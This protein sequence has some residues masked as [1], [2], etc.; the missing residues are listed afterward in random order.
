MNRS[1]DQIE[2]VLGR[3]LAVNPG[4]QF[5][6]NSG[7]TMTVGELIQTVAG[8]PADEFAE[9]V[10]F[11]PLQFGRFIWVHYPNGTVHTGGG[12]V[13]R[14]RDMAKIAQLYLDGGVWQ[15]GR[16]LSQEWIEESIKPQAPGNF[17]GYQWWLRNFTAGGRRYAAFAAEGLGGQFIFV[18]KE[19][20]LVAV[21]TS[22]NDNELWDQPFDMMRQYVLPAAM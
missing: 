7:L 19:L 5:V 1:D 15:G 18:V 16:Y 21:F 22:G 9:Q 2:Y 6:Y 14:P 3:P 11:K 10:L 13:L 12:L 4:S 8:M 17:Y 20:N